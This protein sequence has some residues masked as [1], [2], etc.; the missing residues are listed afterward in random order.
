MSWAAQVEGAQPANGDTI[1]RTNELA[2]PSSYWEIAGLAYDNSVD[3]I[4]FNDQDMAQRVAK[5]LNHAVD[6]C[7]GKPAPKEIF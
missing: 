3:P 7:G 2:S 1:T 5:A 6:L 4:L